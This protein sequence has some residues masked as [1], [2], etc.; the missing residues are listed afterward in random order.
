M[1]PR[2]SLI[3][4][5]HLAPLP[6]SPRWAGADFVAPALADARRY[7]EAGF[8]AVIV[9]NFGDAPFWKEALPPETVAAL[10]LAAGAVRDAFPSLPLG[11]NALRNDARAA[12]GIAAATGA[13]CIRVN[14]HVGAAV[15]DQGIIEGR[16]AETLRA[17]RALGLEGKVALLADVRVKHARPLA[18][19][20]LE[21]A[22]EEAAL[23][24]LADGV[25]VTGPTTGRAPEA[26]DVARARDAVLSLAARLPSGAP[27][28]LLLLGSGL[29]PENASVLA[30]LVDAAIVGTA[31]KR[32]GVTTNEVDPARAAAL[33]AAW[34]A[35]RSPKPEA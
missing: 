13:A 8:D 31:A 23:R 5:V 11:V 27:R 16:A 7:V 14:V 21:V 29:A 30:P 2:G 10:A 17:R 18:D 12:L 28:P 19:L 20:P 25:I 34:R 33:V 22:V 3:G 26:A 4:A 9:E 32:D 35:A 1:L 24:G 6:G 15:T